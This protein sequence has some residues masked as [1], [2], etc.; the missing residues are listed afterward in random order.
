MQLSQY[1]PYGDSGRSC[2]AMLKHIADALRDT[3]RYIPPSLFHRRWSSES[4]QEGQPSAL[5]DILT[6]K[7]MQD[8]LRME[9]CDAFGKFLPSLPGV[10]DMNNYF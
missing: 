9:D 7:Y 4:Q 2:E 10:R 5:L 3:Y 8:H 1:Q 6:S